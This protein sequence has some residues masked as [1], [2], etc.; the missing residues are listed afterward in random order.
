MRWL[1]DDLLQAHDDLVSLLANPNGLPRAAGVI[2][3]LL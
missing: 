3:H 2:A 1:L